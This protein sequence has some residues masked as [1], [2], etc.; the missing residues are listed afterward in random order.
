VFNKWSNNLTQGRIAAAHGRFSHIC[1]VAPMCTPSNTCFL[2]CTTQ[3]A[4]QSTQLFLHS[5]QQTVPILHNGPPLLALK[6]APL[7]GGTGTPI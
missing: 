2:Q 6:S 1:Q 4:S 3:T 7:Q 5:S